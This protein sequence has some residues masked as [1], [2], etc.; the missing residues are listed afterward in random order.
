MAG[1]VDISVVRSVAAT[2]AMCRAA[3]A[4][5]DSARS[6]L[7]LSRSRERAARRSG[8]YEALRLFYDND[9]AQVAAAINARIKE[10]EA[11]DGE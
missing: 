10:L 2:L 3:I 6:D 5:R 9:N 11:T 4:Q 8:L 1:E 7:A